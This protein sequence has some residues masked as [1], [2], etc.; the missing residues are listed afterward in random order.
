[1][2]ERDKILMKDICCKVT[3]IKGIFSTLPRCAS[4]HSL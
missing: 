4:A 2:Q 3:D 1:M